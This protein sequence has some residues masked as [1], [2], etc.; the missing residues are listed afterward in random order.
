MVEPSRHLRR[1][2]KVQRQRLFDV[3][4]IV[5][6]AIIAGY[7][8][9]SRE[10]KIAIGSGPDMGITLSYVHGLDPEIR[11]PGLSGASMD[12]LSQYGAVDRNWV[13]FALGYKQTGGTY[14]PTYYGALPHWFLTIIF[15]MLP[16]TWLYKWRRR[17]KLGPNACPGCGYDL[18][19]NE[20]GVCPECGATAESSSDSA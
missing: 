7:T 2:T 6:S 5:D 19:G 16:A 18:T 9:M 1:L 15:A 20:S 14:I 4:V 10:S 3:A 17:R 12:Y 11:S 8:F 13:R